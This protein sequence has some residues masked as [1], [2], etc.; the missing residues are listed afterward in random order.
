MHDVHFSV[1]V[2][3]KNIQTDAGRGHYSGG[4]VCDIS[5]VLP[6]DVIAFGDVFWATDRR[7]DGFWNLTNIVTRIV[8]IVFHDGRLEGFS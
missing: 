4:P 1:S 7:G 8:A 2:G 3:G 6:R 5:L